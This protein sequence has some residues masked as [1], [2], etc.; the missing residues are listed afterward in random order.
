[1]FNILRLSPTL[2]TSR[3]SKTE[4]FV[5]VFTSLRT[6]LTAN[7]ILKMLMFVALF[8]GLAYGIASYYLTYI[9]DSSLLEMAALEY[10]SMELALPDDLRHAEQKWNLIG[11]IEEAYDE[12]DTTDLVSLLDENGSPQY[13]DESGSSMLRDLKLP[14]QSALLS[15]RE[16]GADFRDIYTDSGLHV[17]L[18]THLMPEGAPAA[19]LQLGRLL[20]EDDR[21]KHRLL[22]FLFISGMLITVTSGT[23]SWWLTGRSLRSTR[24]LWEQQQT[25]VANA[26]HELR[27]PLTLIRASTQ[28]LQLSIDG[29]NPQKELLDDVLVETDYMSRL[30]DDMLMLSRLDA[31]QLKLDLAPI[32]LADLL[33]KV[34]RPF[35]T[36]A[37]EQ[38]VNICVAGAQGTI[39]AD[40]TRFRQVLLILLNNS[41]RHTS[42]GGSITLESKLAGDR[43]IITVADTG[44][45]IPL[46]DLPHV[47]E[48]FYKASNSRSEKRSAGLGLSIAKPLIELH[49]GDITI[50]STLGIKTLVTIRMP[51]YAVE[52]ELRIA[53]SDMTS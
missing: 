7:S 30:V 32:E 25:F 3:P 52:Q 8:A 17:R 31:G 44:Q 2:N 38:E 1:M 6:S 51:A 53:P 13:M 18:Y 34:A 27:T 15:A 48:R 22:L 41:L 45:G 35:V 26:S 23:I 21:V 46:N 42:P 9:T 28:V 24:Q 29:S 47:F 16:N 5:P 20:T 43:V 19:Y 36:L 11:Q 39:L 40:R 49:K 12:E 33:P 10:A 4:D 37:R 50:Q 14:D